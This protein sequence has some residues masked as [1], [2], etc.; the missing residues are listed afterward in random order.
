MSQ[1]SSDYVELK[2]KQISEVKPRLPTPPTPP[3]KKEKRKMKN[4]KERKKKKGEVFFN[5]KGR[6][7]SYV[8]ISLFPSFLKICCVE[9]QKWIVK[10][11]TLVPV[12]KQI[13]GL[14]D[15]VISLFKPSGGKQIYKQTFD[16]RSGDLNSVFIF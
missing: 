8:M 5:K 14:G 10:N 3:K 15:L 2:F 11:T 4:K 13:K 16:D 7:D 1:E 6:Y 12:L 9:L